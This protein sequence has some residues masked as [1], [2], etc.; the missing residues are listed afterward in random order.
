M[1]AD[2]YKKQ[3][4]L[5]AVEHVESGMTLGLGTGS[6]AAHF[7]R[8]LGRRVRD[9]LSVAGVPTSE[10]TRRLAEMAGVD[11]IEPD[12]TTVIDL[13]VDGADELDA[14]LALIKGGGGALLR[15]KIVARAAKRFL[16]IADASKKVAELGAFALPL[17]IEPA[18]FGLTVRAVREALADAGYPGAD[19]AVRAAKD[20]HGP[21]L[22]DGGRYVLDC[23][24]GRIHEP[25]D[26]DRRLAAIPG[27][28]E[29]GLFIDLAH[30][31]ILA[32]PGGLE[33]IRAR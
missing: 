21:F 12:E 19:I 18:L 20:G 32:G 16:V 7:I 30:D 8:E 25:R 31:A 17:E 33:H 28:A 15:E 24:L 14:G 5:A 2:E 23:S 1:N 26:L 9:G 13:D 3:A 27:V 4:A 6:T 29:T 10:E 11:V 22:T